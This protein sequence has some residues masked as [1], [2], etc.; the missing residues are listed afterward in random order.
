MAELLL[1]LLLLILSSSLLLY[2]FYVLVM[3]VGALTYLEP[4]LFLLIT[5]LIIKI[6]IVFSINVYVNI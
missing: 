2:T 5:F 1:L 3:F 4:E 6:L